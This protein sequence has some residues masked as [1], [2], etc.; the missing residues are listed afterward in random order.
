MIAM[1]DED[2]GDSDDKC[3][4]DL[5]IWKRVRTLKQQNMVA[6]IITGFYTQ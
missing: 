2:V 4:D 3:D 1:A 5:S 6:A